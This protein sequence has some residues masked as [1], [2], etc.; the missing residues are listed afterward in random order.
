MGSWKLGTRH[1][2]ITGG[3]W[4]LCNVPK[5]TRFALSIGKTQIH[6]EQ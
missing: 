3:I 1:I 2:Y 6:T 4:T 5:I